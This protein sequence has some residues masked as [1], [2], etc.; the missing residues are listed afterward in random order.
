MVN[1][2]IIFFS[3]DNKGQRFVC[4]GNVKICDYV[5]ILTSGRDM[6]KGEFTLITWWLIS[7]KSHPCYF[8]S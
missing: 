6:N 7:T 5:K 4:R 8:K 1:K 3:L 2:F